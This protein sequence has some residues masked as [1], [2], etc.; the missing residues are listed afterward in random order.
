M[1]LFDP[2]I[3]PTKR[4]KILKNGILDLN[5]P[6][7]KLNVNKIH[8]ANHFLFKNKTKQSVTLR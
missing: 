6:G 2:G 5:N 1:I 4:D 8:T 3:I 7:K